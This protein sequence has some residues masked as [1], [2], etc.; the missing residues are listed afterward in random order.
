MTSDE[1]KA[2]IYRRIA[3]TLASDLARL[4]AENEQLKAELAAAKQP[5]QPTD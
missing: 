1:H 3:D 5:P 2:A 4:L